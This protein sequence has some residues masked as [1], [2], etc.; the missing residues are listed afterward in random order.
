MYLAP[1]NDSLLCIKGAQCPYQIVQVP[2][3]GQFADGVHGK[4]RRTNVD[5]GYAQ[6][7]GGDGA[8]GGAAAHIAAGDKA[9]YWN[10]V[11]LAQVAELGGGFAAG[12]IAL[13]AVDLDHRA[14][15]E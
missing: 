11:L 8:D 10:A 15:V 3:A 1:F 6:L 12:G 9:L 13:V 7:A 4:G 14:L 2:A 5:G